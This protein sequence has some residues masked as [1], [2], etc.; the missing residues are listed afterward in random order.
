MTASVL[1]HVLSTLLKLL[2]PA[3]PY[4]TEEI[5][6]KL[7]GVEDE[8]ICVAS[9]PRAEE[10]L[11]FPEE[12][13]RFLTVIETIAAIRSIRSQNRIPP[14]AQVDVVLIPVGEAQVGTLDWGRPFIERLG[15][16]GGLEI[17]LAAERPELSGA[18][19]TPSGTVF[20]KL[21]GLV[22][23]EEEKARLTRQI[24]KLVQKREQIDRK[25]AN[26][27]FL[28]KAPVEV[29]EE[30]DA[31]KEELQAQIQGLEEHLKSISA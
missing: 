6:Q 12:A 28:E 30:Q 20:V 31:R 7:P 16:V 9:F 27:N 13:S 14:S 8:S 17:A 26:P 25:L 5:W 23:I 1:N 15:R 19:V 11:V 2:H 22:D 21:G 29:I 3:I 24:D 4:I 10:E 18:A